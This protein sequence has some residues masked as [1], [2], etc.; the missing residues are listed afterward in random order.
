MA[1]TVKILTVSSVLL[2]I[3]P[4][5][6]TLLHLI[7]FIEL[8]GIQINRYMNTSPFRSGLIRKHRCKFHSANIWQYWSLGYIHFTEEQLVKAVLQ[9]KIKVYVRFWN[10]YFTIWPEALSVFLTA[11][12][13]A[14]RFFSKHDYVLISKLN[15]SGTAQKNVYYSIPG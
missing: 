9:A 8:I 15:L 13:S 10:A 3:K 2:F 6:F 11:L 4:V 14:V 7:Y 5:V 1:K 12:N